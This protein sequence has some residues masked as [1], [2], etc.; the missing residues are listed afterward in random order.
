M[1]LKSAG[2]HEDFLMHLESLYELCINDDDYSVLL[3]CHIEQVFD[4]FLTIPPASEK[5]LVVFD[6]ILAFSVDFFTRPL[7]L[8]EG[9][10]RVCFKAT[11]NVLLPMVGKYVEH[12]DQGTSLSSAPDL[13]YLSIVNFLRHSL[14]QQSD[15]ALRNLCSSTN[16]FDT[17]QSFLRYA[18]LA[19]SAEESADN[20][21][22]SLCVDS[23]LILLHLISRGSILATMDTGLVH[24]LAFLLVDIIYYCQK[25][26]GIVF[27]ASHGKAT[28]FRGIRIFRYTCILLRT[29]MAHP[30]DAFEIAGVLNR[31]DKDWLWLRSMLQ[32]ENTHLS[33]TMAWSIFGW[34]LS[35]PDGE[36]LAT[37]IFPVWKSACFDAIVAGYARKTLAPP[38]KA[39]EAINNYLLSGYKHLPSPEFKELVSRV[40][41][42][43]EDRDFWAKAEELAKY[44]DGAISYLTNLAKLV[45]NL[46]VFD[47]KSMLN[48]FQK[49]ESLFRCFC[50]N[51]LGKQEALDEILPGQ[52][53]QTVAWNQFLAT[54]EE[55]LSTMRCHILRT[56]IL[57]ALH[58]SEWARIRALDVLPP[59]C[60]IFAEFSSFYRMYSDL[61]K[62]H[63]M[64]LTI[65]GLS[66]RCT[67]LYIPTSEDQSLNINLENLFSK[68][69]SNLHIIRLIFISLLQREDTTI[70]WHAISLLCKLTSLHY[71]Q[72]VDLSLNSIIDE[73]VAFEEDES[74]G[75]VGQ[76]VMGIALFSQLSGMLYEYLDSEEIS[77]REAVLT[78]MQA[79]LGRSLQVKEYFMKGTLGSFKFG[80]K[81]RKTNN[82]KTAILTMWSRQSRRA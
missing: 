67:A 12:L 76:Y 11:Q 33:N 36:I 7:L 40:L 14:S 28:C 57:F 45:F 49:N 43:L 60:T 63:R 39:L 54:D 68:D 72:V 38:E 46:A 9:F 53:W 2:S 8:R 22:Y 77:Q 58:D 65:I 69:G 61:N 27:E 35:T 51:L 42:E 15:Q 50:D 18:F 80:H 25:E 13:L 21:L 23:L 10:S 29:L 32:Y 31:K 24:S 79:L 73:F 55:N 4:R 41:V 82:N 62:M 17:L 71:G 70:Q 78:A 34:I 37:K 48:N 64:H 16:I 59:L 56:F 20:S 66:I 52:G 75:G 6:R 44:H 30:Q 3:E 74:S 1:N 47:T 19:F 26:I 5:D 81:S